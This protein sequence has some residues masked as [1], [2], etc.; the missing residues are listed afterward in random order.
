M[1]KGAVINDECIFLNLPVTHTVV[2]EQESTFWAITKTKL[3]QMEEKNPRLALAITHHILKYATTMRQRLERDIHGLEH[4]S[5][6]QEKI[7]ASK[8]ST[9]YSHALAQNLVLHIRENH[10]AHLR[11]RLHWKQQHGVDD[12]HDHEHDVTL[13]QY[14]A[15]HHV[16]TFQHIDL[17]K[18]RKEPG[19]LSNTLEKLHA[20]KHS[21]W[22]NTKP[23]SLKYK[24]LKPESG[25]SF[26]SK[27]CLPIQNPHSSRKTVL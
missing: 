21:V 3:K 23:H 9:H 24:K 27:I 18:F 20:I 13:A 22:E 25:L 17:E 16:H 11:Q 6:P 15:D 12:E 8:F 14:D 7:K 10:D 4:F 5:K 1:T 19:K 2:V 26:I